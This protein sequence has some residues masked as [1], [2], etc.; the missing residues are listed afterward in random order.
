MCCNLN[1]GLFS[2]ALLKKLMRYRILLPNFEEA[3]TM[4]NNAM[5]PEIHIN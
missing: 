5:V 4:Q 3:T 1:L 2:S